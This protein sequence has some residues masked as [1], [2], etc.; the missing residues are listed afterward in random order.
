MRAASSGRF[1]LIV[2]GLG[3][4]GLCFRRVL[5]RPPLAAEELGILV[6]DLPGYGRSPWPAEP[7]SLARVAE[8]LR[9]WVPQALAALDAPD[10][11]EVVL[12]GHSMGGVIGQL[13]CEGAELLA[14]P[15]AGPGTSSLPRARLAG[16]FDVEGNLSYGDCGYSGR[17]APFTLDEFVE[18][19]H[20]EVC[21]QI[22]ELAQDDQAHRSYFASA[23]FS[24]PRV[25]HRHSLELVE[26]SRG[27]GLARRF[28]RL[29]LP[30][31][32]L[33]GAPRGAARRS[34]QLLEEAGVEPLVIEPAG[35][36]PFIDQPD[37][38]ASRL[39][40]FLAEDV[41]WMAS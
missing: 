21:R 12:V 41:G 35:H 10:S 37:E 1:V 39:A 33:L 2:H 11:C 31:A 4:S 26:L 23:S 38:F 19:G 5:E 24:D 8:Q 3:E 16:F 32:Y 6:P 25:F 30:R 40:R 27:E 34:R 9:A 22:L 14:A 29:E 20:T 17:A 28:A 7:L 13:I 15:D 18:H 36:W